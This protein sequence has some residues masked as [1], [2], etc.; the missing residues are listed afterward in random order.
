MCFFNRGVIVIDLFS[1]AVM[2]EACCATNVFL[3]AAV[4]RELV[5][6]ISS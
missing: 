6:C 3:T 1:Y 4:A 5:Q 2:D